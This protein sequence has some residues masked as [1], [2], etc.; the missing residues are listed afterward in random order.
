MPSLIL[1]VSVPFLLFFPSFLLLFIC[2]VHTSQPLDRFKFTVS[3]FCF[4]PKS[5][6]YPYSN[7]NPNPYTFSLIKTSLKALLFA[8]YY[9]ISRTIW[10]SRIALLAFLI[11]SFPNYKKLIRD[12]KALKPQNFQNLY[13]HLCIN[14]QIIITALYQNTIA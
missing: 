10:L 4:N 9:G 13:H 14:R 5:N 7:K 3:L 6:T 1:L 12:T 2:T 11:Q 8:A